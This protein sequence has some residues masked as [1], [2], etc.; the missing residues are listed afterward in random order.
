MDQIYYIVIIA[1]ITIANSVVTWL[2]WRELKRSQQRTEQLHTGQQRQ[3]REISQHRYSIALISQTQK[4]NEN[5]SKKKN[6]D[7]MVDDIVFTDESVNAAIEE[8]IGEENQGKVEEK[9]GEA[10]DSMKDNEVLEFV[11]KA[12]KA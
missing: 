5:K 10:F 3:S 8:L 1:L 9:T 11:K 12:K 2:V 6:L 4:N 7:A